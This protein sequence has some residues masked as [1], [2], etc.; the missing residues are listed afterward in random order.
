MNT[1]A[2]PEVLPG[3]TRCIRLNIGA[4]KDEK[5]YITVNFNGGRAFEVFIRCDDPKLHE[6][7]NAQTIL[8]TRMLRAGI[9]LATIG[10]ELQEIHSAGTSDHHAEG[11]RHIGRVARIGQMLETMA[12]LGDMITGQGTLTNE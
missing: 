2:R 1:E 10:K 9:S 3:V 11:V 12:G 6:W 5:F 4:E 7:V 8:I